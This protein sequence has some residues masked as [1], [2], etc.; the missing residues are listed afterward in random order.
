MFTWDCCIQCHNAVSPTFIFGIRAFGCEVKVFMVT[1]L[2]HARYN[3]RFRSQSLSAD[4]TIEFATR[5]PRTTPGY[6]PRLPITPAVRTPSTSSVACL[7]SLVSLCSREPTR[8]ILQRTCVGI[9]LQCTA[10]TMTM[11]SLFGIG[12]RRILTVLTFPNPERMA[13]RRRIRSRLSRNSKDNLIWIAEYERG[14]CMTA[15]EWLENETG[16]DTRTKRILRMFVDVVDSYRILL[17]GWDRQVKTQQW[18]RIS[19]YVTTRGSI[20]THNMLI[21]KGR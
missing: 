20:Y 5:S 21:Y 4:Q 14:G 2:T 13:R 11:V 17:V 15:L 18:M 1:H 6:G 10:S 12:R 19:F 8:G 9:W 7:P 3:A 16:L